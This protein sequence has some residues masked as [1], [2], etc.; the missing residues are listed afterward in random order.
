MKQTYSI[1]TVI[2]KLEMPP[3]VP[4]ALFLKWNGPGIDGKSKL[5]LPNERFHELEEQLHSFNYCR[6]D[7]NFVCAL[8]GKSLSGAFVKLGS[9]DVKVP[10]ELFAGERS[11]FEFPIE[12]EVGRF[13]LSLSFSILSESALPYELVKERDEAQIGPYCQ[14]VEA[15]EPVFYNEAAIRAAWGDTGPLR[16]LE[17]HSKCYIQQ[18]ALAT[19]ASLESHLKSTVKQSESY[20]FCIE[21]VF[22]W[23]MKPQPCF[24]TSANDIVEYDPL[25]DMTSAPLMPVLG[26]EIS[27]G[28]DKIIYDFGDTDQGARWAMDV[29]SLIVKSIDDKC[30]TDEWL[31]YFVAAIYFAVMFVQARYKRELPNVIDS[32]LVVSRHA[33]TVLVTREC[34]VIREMAIRPTDLKT[35]IQS[36]QAIFEKFCVPEDVWQEILC[37]LY[38]VVD[39]HAAN[40]W[41][42][43][44][45]EDKVYSCEYSACFPKYNWPLL[46]DLDEIVTNCDMIVAG[47]YSIK[48]ISCELKGKWL[49]ETLMKMRDMF[50][51]KLSISRINAIVGENRCVPTLVGITRFVETNWSFEIPK[52]QIPNT[53]PIID[54]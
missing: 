23:M 40:R 5:F 25:T 36:Q 46:S 9:L 26:I 43:T 49:Y 12:T 54:F 31:V 19:V 22:E 37:Y 10:D 4:Y 34:A 15:L 52:M 30:I 32:L 14:K 47:K 21:R 44:G 53:L 18:G 29:C 24:L 41:I 38:D 2:E 11:D 28:I 27:C 45:I 39:Y 33:L 16:L 20:K 3:G 7:L 1:R 6:G 51:H 50:N 35:Y 8:I 42:L 17:Q 13:E 48:H